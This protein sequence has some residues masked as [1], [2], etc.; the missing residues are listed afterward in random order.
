MGV[1]ND[2]ANW[3]VILEGGMAG[4]ESTESS[5]KN[6]AKGFKNAVSRLIPEPINSGAT[7]EFLH[8]HSVK[9]EKR[10]LFRFVNHG[11]AVNY[12]DWI[13]ARSNGEIKPTDLYIFSTGERIT[14]TIRRGFLPVAAKETGVFNKLVVGDKEYVK[15]WGKI[16]QMN[17]C[18]KTK[19]YQEGLAAY[20]QLPPRMKVDKNV[21]LIRLNLAQKAGDQEYSEAIQDLVTNYPNDPCSEIVAI[22]AYFL[23]KEYPKVLKCI[24]RLDREVGGDPYLKVMRAGIHIKSGNLKEG[25]LACQKAIEEEPT[26]K[27]AY[28]SLVSISLREKK[29]DETANHLEI[30][31]DKFH[32]EI[33]DLTDVPDYAE[34]IRSPEYQK[35]AKSREK[36]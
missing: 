22:D 32:E 13:L 6:F 23:R 27:Q 16:K 1:A 12:H 11:G 14:E 24:D 8:T 31:A 10:V 19:N 18:L 25:R 2:L 20:R 3:D 9:D 36:E 28:W 35:W 21:L 26:L 33:G 30:L 5:R 7:Y 4:V 17:D 29:F 34:F 15:N